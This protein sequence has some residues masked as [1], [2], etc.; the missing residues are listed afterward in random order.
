MKN[1]RMV[2]RNGGRVEFMSLNLKNAKAERLARELARRTGESLT[3]AVTVALEE[4]LE[5]Q[6]KVPQSLSRLE[7]MRKI[8]ERTAPLMK[9][10]PPS[11][12][13][14]DELYDEDGLPK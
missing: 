14:F 11:K 10:M 6:K 12:E 7:R 1:D 8:V 2:Q 3:L 9:N 5:R 13:L 4:R